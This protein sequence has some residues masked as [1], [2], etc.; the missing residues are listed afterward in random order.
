MYRIL[1]DD[2]KETKKKGGYENLMGNEG[3][4]R[5]GRY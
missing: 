3:K 2:F 4:C 1:K 5:K